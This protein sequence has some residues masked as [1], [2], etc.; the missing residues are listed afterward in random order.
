MTEEETKPLLDF[1]M[2]HAVAYE[3]TYRHRWTVNDLIMWDNRCT[4]HIALCDYDL[5]N[6]PRTML[7]CSVIGEPSGHDYHGDDDALAR[8]GSPTLAT[9]SA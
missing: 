7:K 5:R 1:L 4:M 9:L 2:E 8:I 6:D 3:F